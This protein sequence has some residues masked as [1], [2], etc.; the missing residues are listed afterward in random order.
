MTAGLDTENR[1]AAPLAANYV[2]VRGESLG[3]VAA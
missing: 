3:P 1:L 2:A